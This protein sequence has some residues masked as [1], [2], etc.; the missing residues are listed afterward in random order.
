MRAK[1]IGHQERIYPDYRDL[2][3][4][5]TL[6][7]QPGTVYDIGVTASRWPL[8]PVPPDGRSVTEPAKKTPP[9]PR[10]AAEGGKTDGRS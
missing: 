10:P 1:Y 5:A 8:P 7:A 6:T 4:G 2:S 3:T 9:A